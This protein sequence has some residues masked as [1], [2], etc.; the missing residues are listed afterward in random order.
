[1]NNEGNIL[2]DGTYNILGKITSSGIF[3]SE[4]GAEYMNGTFVQIMTMATATFNNLTINNAAS[5][6]LIS[7][8]TIIT[9]TLTINTE[10]VFKI[11][12]DKNLTVTGTIINSA[13]T[14]S[15][16]LKSNASGTASLLHNTPMNR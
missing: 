2:G 12:A 5:V 10:K 7:K 8:Q 4:A 6:T 11:E 16:I 14:S 13:D 1:M 15:L 3:F 9:N